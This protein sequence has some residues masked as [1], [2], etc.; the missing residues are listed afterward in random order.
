MLHAGIQPG[1]P[2]LHQYI[3]TL[4]PHRGG[5]LLEESRAAGQ[6][7]NISSAALI[8]AHPQFLVEKESLEMSYQPHMPP[9][10]PGKAKGMLAMQTG[11]RPCLRGTFEIKIDLFC[12]LHCSGTEAFSVPAHSCL[13]LA[14]Q[15]LEAKGEHMTTVKHPSFEEHLKPAWHFLRMLFP[16]KKS[17]R[18]LCVTDSGIRTSWD[19]DQQ[20][21]VTTD[22]CA[23]LRPQSFL[24]MGILMRGKIQP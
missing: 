17:S 3:P 9:S 14:A 24:N 23:L 8:F 12:F 20:T 1:H 7:E 18:S 13:A 4:A 2:L 16:E 10:L 6:R 11:H 19:R 22:F 5:E 15:P 21:Q